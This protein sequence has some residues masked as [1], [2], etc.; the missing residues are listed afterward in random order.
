MNY[1]DFYEWAASRFD[2]VICSG[3]EI[4]INSLWIQDY[5]HHCYC[6]VNKTVFHC[7]KSGKSG[8]LYELISKVD[9]ISV[10]EARSKMGE[11]DLFLLEKRIDVYYK[12][13]QRKQKNINGLKFPENT[14]LISSIPT[15]L[16][17][18][19]KSE[20]YLKER[21]LPIDGLYYC[22]GGKYSNRIIIPYWYNDELIYWNGRT[23]IN[24][25]L[26]YYGP[27]KETGVGKADVLYARD[28]PQRGSKIYL[29]E[30]EFDAMSLSESGLNG[31][32]CG[33]KELS[34]KQVGFI[35][36][37]KICLAF[38]ADEGGF[39]ALNKIGNKLLSD[40]MSNI[41][42]VRPP[43]GIKDW[44]KFLADMNKEMLKLY[45][46]KT[47]KEFNIWTSLHKLYSKI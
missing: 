37:Y 29:T 4:R 32:A 26:R 41:S 15:I 47:E 44:N 33:G 7:W 34:D 22:N 6:N 14:T 23:I 9:N 1:D 12:G 20:N 2:S 16:P 11:N 35:K 39:E 18:R 30:G 10:E 28:W 36:D 46:E 17:D 8:S 3:D 27:D 21:K 43:S 5:K 19:T 40:G 24:S 25:S 38:D 13:K 45:I 31:V 42:Y